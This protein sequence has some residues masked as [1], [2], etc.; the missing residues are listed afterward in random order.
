M[1][2]DEQIEALGWMS[3]TVRRPL[4]R[5]L[6]SISRLKGKV[7]ADQEKREAVGAVEA[8]VWDALSQCDDM[9]RICREIRGK[10]GFGHDGNFPKS[11]REF[12][13]DNSPIGENSRCHL[14]P[15]G[16]SHPA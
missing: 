7:Q 3:S 6:L 1:S 13:P 8:E 4:A 16:I 14:P 5:V 12:S 10:R 15:R 2:G 11:R 9:A